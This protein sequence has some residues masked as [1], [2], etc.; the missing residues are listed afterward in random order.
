MV[1]IYCLVE[2]SSTEMKVYPSWVKH[3]IPNMDV[4]NKVEDRVAFDSST[5]SCYFI[6]GYGYP[7][8][9]NH[10]VH[11]ANDISQIP[12]ITHFVVILDCDEDTV[13]QRS[14]IIMSEIVKHAVLNTV[15]V[16]VVIQNRCVETVF[17]GNK[18]IISRQPQNRV[19]S[20]YLSYYD[21][22]LSSLS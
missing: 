21:V 7:L 5:N 22:T 14:E 11:A 1:K 13:Q 17:L 2:G 8:I 10:I 16:K 19:F 18:K 20:E 12:D 3:T 15:D 4:F 6:S 9:V